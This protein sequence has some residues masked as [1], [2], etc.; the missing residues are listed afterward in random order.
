MVP[1][2]MGGGNYKVEAPPHSYIDVSDFDSV[3][4][5]ALFLKGIDKNSYANYFKWKREFSLYQQDSWCTLCH[6]LHDLKEPW[7][8]YGNISEWYYNDSHGNYLC[9]NGSER[10]YYASMF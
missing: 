10:N 9:S 1:I 6:K 8:T 4:D 2:V 3:E 7:K 5:L